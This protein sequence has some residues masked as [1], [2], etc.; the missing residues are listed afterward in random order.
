MTD[1]NLYYDTNMANKVQESVSTEED[2]SVDNVLQ[3]YGYRDPRTLEVKFGNMINVGSFHAVLEPGAKITIPKGYHDG[4]GDV[5]SISIESYT[6]GTAKEEDIVSNK[7]AWVNG[8]RIV[9]TF[10]K[11][12]YEQDAT[13][14]EEDLWNGKTAWVNGVKITGKM[15]VYPREDISLIAGQAFTILQGFHYETVVSAHDLESQTQATAAEEDILEGKTAWVNGIEIIGSF[16]INKYIENVLN[17]DANSIDIR[18]GKQV[19]TSKGVIT[20]SMNEYLQ[21]S[22]RTV[23]CGESYTIPEGYHDGNGIIKGETLLKQTS[24]DATEKDIRTGKTA[25]VN[26]KKIVGEMEQYV[27]DA[28]DTTATAYNISEGTTAYI[29]GSKREG[30]CPYNIVNFMHQADN[31]DT[32][33]EVVVHVLPRYD[34]KTISHMI[35]QLVD[36]TTGNIVKECVISDY[37]NSTD[38]EEEFFT[39]SS[40]RGNDKISI[41]PKAILSVQYIKSLLIGFT[42][43]TE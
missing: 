39:L 16:N 5:E 20:G 10:D 40:E 28:S 26:G 6:Y 33:S 27:T 14:T 1:D 42:I 37:L 31:V 18:N 43:Y 22:P 29:N 35:I 7:V 8:K 15:P 30:K 21:E 34:W 32:P 3:N 25:W 17:N 38:V 19:M 41:M 4:T 36:S 23:L 12:A 24:A 2:A 13:A 9:G 11:D